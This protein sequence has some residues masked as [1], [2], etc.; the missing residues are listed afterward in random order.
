MQL[1]YHRSM[2]ARLSGILI[3]KHPL[4]GIIDVNGVGYKVFATLPTLGA[5]TVG[6]KVTLH[7]YMYV[8]ENIQDIYGFEDKEEKALFELLISVS[9]IGRAHV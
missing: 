4:F 2:I 6:E 9:E 7:T 3:E 8:R 1:V 5:T